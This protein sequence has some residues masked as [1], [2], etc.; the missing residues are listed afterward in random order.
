M[1]KVRVSN[2]AA[3]ATNNK[4]T[5]KNMAGGEKARKWTVFPGKN[6]FGCDGRCMC[7]P[8]YQGFLFCLVLIVV[9]GNKAEGCLKGYL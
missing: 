1:A 4:A 5:E 2:S 7:S 6:K 3:G 8:D 9:T